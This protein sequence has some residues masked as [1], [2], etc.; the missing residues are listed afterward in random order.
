[1]E[2][3]LPIAEVN[4]NAFEILLLSAIVGVLSGLF[5]VGGGFLM[6]PFLIFLG[7]PPAYAVANE[8]NNILAT[9]VSGST[10]HYLKNTLDYKMGLMIVAG[11]AIGTL[12]GI[13]TFS[14]F[15]DMGKI[16]VVIALAYMYILAIIGSLML[17]ESL[18]EIDKQR[19]N[20]VVKKKLHVHYWIHGLPFRLRFPKSKLYES[21][22]TPIII[23][24]FVGFIAAIMGI[25]G[26]FILVPAMIYI[27]GMPTKLVP[28]TSLFVTIFVS[29]IVTFLHAFNYGSIDLLLVLMLVTGSIIGVQVGQKLGEKINSSG[30]RALLAILLL[31]VGIAMAYDTFFTEKVETE[32]VKVLDNDLNFFS[33]FIQKFSQEM[34][35][36]YSLFTIM[37]AIFLGVAAAFIRRFFSN[38][39]KKLAVPANK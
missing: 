3:Y 22:F 10:T 6:T 24:L 5:G 14:Y 2:V 25:G 34:P 30:L 39:R 26:A 21:A 4:I 9:S 38:L 32:I 8:A 17:V 1:M 12:L 31:L 28:G 16:D 23:G 29:V 11:G 27:I 36:F 35:L 7:V 20:V 19:R 15:Q 37:F 13:Y 33:V 18:G